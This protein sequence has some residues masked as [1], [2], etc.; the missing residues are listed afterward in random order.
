MRVSLLIP[1]CTWEWGSE[2]RGERFVL[3]GKNTAV[4]NRLLSS[5]SIFTPVWSK[6]DVVFTLVPAFW[7]EYSVCCLSTYLSFCPSVCLSSL[8]FL[9]V[10]HFLPLSLCLSFFRPLFL[11]LSV[12]LSLSL[13]I[14]LFLSLSLSQSFSFV[15]FSFVSFSYPF[16]P[17]VPLQISCSF[18]SLSLHFYR[19]LLLCLPVSLHCLCLV[20]LS[21]SLSLSLY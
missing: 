8:F 4:K 3:Q 9:S 18:L 1:G 6:Q 21:L 5:V 19:A 2:G 11:F 20:S 14:F 15:S 13:Y 10:S 7:R 16:S 12:S 17:S